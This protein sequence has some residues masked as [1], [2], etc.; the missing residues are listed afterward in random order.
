MFLSL[1]RCIGF[2]HYPAFVLGLLGILGNPVYH[3]INQNDGLY[4][5]LCKIF[6]TCFKHGTVS[7]PVNSGTW[8][9]SWITGTEHHYHFSFNVGS[10][11]VV[12][13]IFLN[14]V[15]DKYNLIG[16][17]SETVIAD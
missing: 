13:V 5:V 10:V 7:C 3:R 17:E 16:R 9:Y 11:K 4:V 12:V 2:H 6:R 1:D 15:T 8:L 14:S